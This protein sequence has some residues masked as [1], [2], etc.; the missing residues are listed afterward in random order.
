MSFSPYFNLCLKS[1]PHLWNSAL[2]LLKASAFVQAKGTNVKASS[3]LQAFFLM[4]S[5]SPSLPLSPLPFSPPYPLP[6]THFIPLKLLTRPSPLA[7]R[8]SR[9]L[10]KQL[11]AFILHASS[12]QKRWQEILSKMQICCSEPML[13]HRQVRPT[14]LSARGPSV[15]RGA[16]PWFRG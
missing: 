10:P 16:G 9:P 2:A 1:F 15:I 5:V 7:A 13:L 3:P 12:R 8:V 11:T 6:Q 14:S 4:F